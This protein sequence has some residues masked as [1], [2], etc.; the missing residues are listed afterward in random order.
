ML[1]GEDTSVTHAVVVVALAA[2]WFVTLCLQALLLYVRDKHVCRLT[3]CTA[4][5]RCNYMYIPAQVTRKCL[6]HKP[7]GCRPA[8]ECRQCR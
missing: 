2:E 8:Y 3:S 4:P 7:T 5:A 1:M 6:V